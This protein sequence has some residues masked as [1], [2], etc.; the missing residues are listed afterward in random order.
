GYYTQD[1]SGLILCGARWYNPMLGHWLSR[2]PIEYDGG[3]NLYEY[4]GSDPINWTDP[5]GL[6]EIVVG[7]P[8]RRVT[9]KLR[10]YGDPGDRYR[11]QRDGEIHT[12]TQR[13]LLI[14]VNYCNRTKHPHADPFEEEANGPFPPRT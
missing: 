12:L 6:I 7:H 1:P 10:V 9:G 13:Q 8:G 14:S 11:S 5:D 2:D 3:S 4:C